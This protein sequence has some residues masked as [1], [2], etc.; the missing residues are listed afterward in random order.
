VTASAPPPVKAAVDAEI[1][2]SPVS[3]E[4]HEVEEPVAAKPVDSDGQPEDY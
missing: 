4:D 3:P 1:E 2:A